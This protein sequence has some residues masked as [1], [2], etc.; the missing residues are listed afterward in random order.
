MLEA[1][2]RYRW[3]LALGLTACA[4]KGT[5]RVGPDAGQEIPADAA[6]PA[7]KPDA[8]VAPDAAPGTE[9][10]GPAPDLGETP[11]GGTSGGDGGG[12]SGGSPSDALVWPN[13]QSHTNS[14]RWLMEHHTEIQELH[15]RFL[16]IDFANGRTTAQS[17]ARFQTQ[18]EAMMEG[19]RYHGYSNPDAKPF[20]IYEIAKYVDLKDDP[21]PA[22]WTAPNSTKMPRRNGGINFGAL[23]TQEYADHYAIPDPQNPGH[24]LTLTEL[25]A[26]GIVNDV[27]IIFNKTA[28]D[29][30][31]PEILEYK[32]MYDR[33]DVALPGRF[34]QYA[35]N[36]SFDATDLPYLK[37]IGRSLR[38]SFLE[39]NGNWTNAMEV[40]GHNYEHIGERAVLRFYEMWKPFANRDLDTRF[41]TAFKDWYACPYGMPCLSYPTDNS[42]TYTIRSETRTLDP[43]DQGCGSAHFPPNARAQ[44]DKSNPQVV[45]STCEHYGLH[46]GPGGKDL[47]TP[48]SL[49]TVDR[50][51]NT[52]VGRGFVGGGWFMYWFQSFPGYGN[53]AKMAD[54]S[55]MKNW[56]VYL[57]Y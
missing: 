39:M 16:L 19:S 6:A 2:S 40:N 43:F 55:P 5:G 53:Q 9:R 50:W 36:G 35:G 14:D 34:D 29:N 49:A 30:N 42:V 24:N 48:Y 4:A 25:V 46:D 15:P 21:I 44:Y 20:L 32:Q 47:K 11:T 26:K 57:Y 52:P 18:K 54:G 38:I 45:M 51:K 8:G 33:N 27:F 17:M 1:I 10:P 28:P 3:L 12:G 23:F 31:V 37:Q 41:Q 13:E 22:G 56:W 7:P